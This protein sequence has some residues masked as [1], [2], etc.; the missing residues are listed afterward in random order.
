MISIED[1]K[2]VKVKLYNVLSRSPC[3][4][5]C[6]KSEVLRLCGVMEEECFSISNSVEGYLRS[7]NEKINIYA[8]MNDRCM[9]EGSRMGGRSSEHVNGQRNMRMNEND[10]RMAECNMSERNSMRMNENDARMAE[11]NMNER[12]SMRMNENDARMNTHKINMNKHAAMHLRNGL[13]GVSSHRSGPGQD[14][15]ATNGP[16]NMDNPSI[17]Y[18]MNIHRSH[19][20]PTHS[21]NNA[22]FDPSEHAM[23]SMNADVNA[24]YA[25]KRALV[26]LKTKNETGTA[27]SISNAHNTNPQMAQPYEP[28]RRENDPGW[29]DMH[30]NRSNTRT[31]IYNSNKDQYEQSMRNIGCRGSTRP[32]SYDTPP[33]NNAYHEFSNNVLDAK[34]QD[35]PNNGKKRVD[36][37]AMHENG[38]LVDAAGPCSTDLNYSSVGSSHGRLAER[39]S[40][41]SQRYTAHA[42]NTAARSPYN[43]NRRAEGFSGQPATVPDQRTKHAVNHFYP[44]AQ[45]GQHPNRSVPNA[46]F[47]CV[48]DARPEKRPFTDKAVLFQKQSENNLNTAKT[49]NKQK[50]EM[51]SNKETATSND[52]A[53]DVPTG[54]NTGAYDSSHF[55][56]MHADASRSGSMTKQK[57]E[58]EKNY[59]PP[60]KMQSDTNRQ[61]NS[62]TDK[63]AIDGMRMTGTHAS[64]NYGRVGNINAFNDSTTGD[65]RSINYSNAYASIDYQKYAYEN[66]Q[67]AYLDANHASH[68]NKMYKSGM[69]SINSDV[70][71]MVSVKAGHGEINR[72]SMGA[73]HSDA[74]RACDAFSSYVAATNG[75]AS[76]SGQAFQHNGE[77]LRHAQHNTDMTTNTAYTGVISPGTNFGFKN[78]KQG[79]TAYYDNH[80]NDVNLRAGYTDNHT[81]A[82]SAGAVQRYTYKMVQP[83]VDSAQTMNKHPRQN[84][85]YQRPAAHAQHHNNSHL[86][87]T[88]EVYPNGAGF[89]SRTPYTGE[90]PFASHGTYPNGQNMPINAN[91]PSP[92]NAY[93]N[94]QQSDR[95]AAAPTPNAYDMPNQRSLGTPVHQNHKNEQLHKNQTI[96][97]A[98]RPNSHLNSTRVISRVPGSANVKQ[99]D[100]L[101]RSTCNSVLKSTYYDA[102][103]TNGRDTN[104]YM[105]GGQAFNSERFT[106]GVQYAGDANTVRCDTNGISRFASPNGSL[107]TA[108]YA[109]MNGHASFNARGT[110]K[111]M[112]NYVKNGIN[113]AQQF[114]DNA[115]LLRVKNTYEQQPKNSLRT[116]TDSILNG[117]FASRTRNNGGTSAPMNS[118]R[119]ALNTAMHESVGHKS[120]NNVQPILENV[121]EEIR[122]RIRLDPMVNDNT[123]LNGI[124][125]MGYS[126]SQRVVSGKESS[127]V[128]YIKRMSGNP[129]YLAGSTT[130]SRVTSYDR[131]VNRYDNSFNARTTEWHSNKNVNMNLCSLKELE[132]GKILRNSSINHSRKSR[133]DEQA[134]TTKNALRSGDTDDNGGFERMMTSNA[135][136]RE[137][138]NDDNTISDGVMS[139][140]GDVVKN[141]S[142]SSVGNTIHGV[143]MSIDGNTINNISSGNTINNIGNGVKKRTIDM[144]NTIGGAIRSSDGST[145]TNINI[146]NGNTITKAAVKR[147]IDMVNTT[148]VVKSTLDKVCNSPVNNVQV[149][150]T[151]NGNTPTENATASTASMSNASSV[152][153]NYNGH[154][155][156][157]GTDDHNGINATLYGNY[158]QSGV[159]K[160]GRSTVGDKNGERVLDRY[161][162]LG[163]TVESKECDVLPCTTENEM[164]IKRIKVEVKKMS[165]EEMI[166]K[167]IMDIKTVKSNDELMDIIEK[168]RKYFDERE[169]NS[170]D[171]N[172]IVTADN[173]NRAKEEVNEEK[174]APTL[175]EEDA[176]CSSA[177]INF[178]AINT[179]EDKSMFKEFKDFLKM[180]QSVFIAYD[181]KIKQDLTYRK[182]K[183]VS[184]LVRESNSDQE[185]EYFREV[186]EHLKQNVE[187]VL[188]E[189]G[190]TTEFSYA[191]WINNS[192]AKF[193]KRL[194]KDHSFC[195][196]LGKSFSK[197]LNL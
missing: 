29:S 128:E 70:N 1:R 46:Q 113:A 82:P 10:A 167:L 192:I 148:G 67:K 91:I 138:S 134:D 109:A 50:K 118:A 99:K 141:R 149:V 133:T 68:E 184:R 150:N 84:A 197:V 73:G 135:V 23:A 5:E 83:S 178:F 124:S 54:R 2:S 175:P 96:T 7:I 105:N 90:Y 104:M 180:A 173:D 32:Y 16:V 56:V 9:N 103:V 55:T 19:D 38:K 111:N 13:F 127:S 164:S 140:A 151:S 27:H 188:E 142:S 88:R 58:N 171:G 101:E 185:I 42:D 152:G 14:Y 187:K 137:R 144:V 159:Q 115:G 43:T 121:Q 162:G 74:N 86:G 136:V 85:S 132:S 181:D 147:T 158:Q 108:Q 79:S 26:N 93:A 60:E 81:T 66:M 102:S 39:S 122:K 41:A 78:V 28:V 53:A 77:F 155:T 72:S 94:G 33:R 114:V 51:S 130:S 160:G 106:S 146:S 179:E 107:S 3:F 190:Q 154:T 4:S 18:D 62:C 183:E 123:V 57:R 92:R 59:V 196:E 168:L 40:C 47:A 95:M 129:S 125:M 191:Y 22:R 194:K 110:N 25:H 37:Y 100:Y 163:I 120:I 76:S 126:K 36:N 89:S 49:K 131:P 186:I 195:I 189:H 64:Y 157:T 75:Q 176:S 65:K 98:A 61:I 80:T 97:D 165:R 117:A 166:K 143:V 8:R 71:R 116:I 48:R 174:T 177:K 172:E 12:N 145:I 87:R 52:T 182:Y 119:A 161:R 21:Y 139:R 112:N 17:A 30:E 15:V 35:M 63:R 69:N 170:K 153:N 11:C 34:G 169:D 45:N 44:F 193:N 156:Y 6:G 31:S 24:N 20:A